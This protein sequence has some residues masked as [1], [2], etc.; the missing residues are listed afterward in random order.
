MDTQQI[1]VAI[2]KE[3]TPLTVHSKT[4]EELKQ[5][6][7]AELFEMAL[8]ETNQIATSTGAEWVRFY[9]ERTS[10]TAM[11]A[12]DHLK[13]KSILF[14]DDYARKFVLGAWIALHT[15]DEN[16]AQG[17]AISAW[18]HAEGAKHMFGTR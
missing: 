10:V 1:M 11:E 13:L 16:E 6:P 4:V 12:T 18:F 14:M 9:E 2:S 7:I 15:G 3:F 17:C 8:E 5:L